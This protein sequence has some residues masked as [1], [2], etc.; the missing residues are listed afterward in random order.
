[1]IVEMFNLP[2][3]EVAIALVLVLILLGADEVLVPVRLL[4]YFN[5]SSTQIRNLDLNFCSSICPIPVSYFATQMTLLPTK[6][7]VRLLG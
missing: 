7:V 1:M 2:P 6:C 3:V 5:Q 4:R